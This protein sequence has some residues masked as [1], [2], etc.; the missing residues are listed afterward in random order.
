MTTWCPALQRCPCH[1]KVHLCRGH[2]TQT[3]TASVQQVT[4]MSVKVFMIGCW[5]DQESVFIGTE[6]LFDFMNF[7]CEWLNMGTIYILSS[8]MA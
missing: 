2:R 7:L 8:D 4:C 3:H 1:Q 6:G 5:T